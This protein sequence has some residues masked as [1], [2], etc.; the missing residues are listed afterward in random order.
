MVL[1]SILFVL[2][3]VGVLQYKLMKSRAKEEE[4]SA[5][6]WERER[7]ANFTRKQPL[8]V[9]DYIKIPLEKLPFSE[10]DDPEEKEIQERILA[11]SKENI[12][13]VS[14]MTN[15]DIKLAYGTGNFQLISQYDQNFLLLQR[16]LC[17]WGC[18]LYEHGSKSAAKTVLEYGVS[19]DCDI[20]RCYTTLASIYQEEMD[21]ISIKDLMEHVK[22]LNTLMKD[23]ILRQLQEKLP[24]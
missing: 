24:T 12:L 15:T 21:Y 18:L 5:D 14:N 3:W 17:Q 1:R 4:T 19:L 10:T 23:S 8:P 11:L 9:D 20:S 13:N 6:F 2:I 7:R 22:D 16:L